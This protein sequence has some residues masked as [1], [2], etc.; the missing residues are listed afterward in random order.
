[1]QKSDGT[2]VRNENI[3]SRKQS[4]LTDS[5]IPDANRLGGI[6]GDLNRWIP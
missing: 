5:P 4:K 1:M 3:R 6:P 2:N